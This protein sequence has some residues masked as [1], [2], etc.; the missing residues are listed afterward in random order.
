[1]TQYCAGYVAKGKTISTYTS[2]AWTPSLEDLQCLE[3]AAL[4]VGGMHDRRT[5]LQDIEVYTADGQ[6][7]MLSDL[8]QA[9]S[10]HSVDYIDGA[11]LLCGG[12]DNDGGRRSSRDK[13][14]KGEYQPST[15]GTL[16]HGYFWSREQFNSI[17]FF[18]SIHTEQYNF[19]LFISTPQKCNLH[20]QFCTHFKNKKCR[21]LTSSYFACFAQTMQSKQAMCHTCTFTSLIIIYGLTISMLAACNNC[22]LNIIHRYNCAYLALMGY[23]MI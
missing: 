10:L 22:N 6:R 23:F 12:K 18:I 21:A 20:T 7:R 17:Q 5:R 9:I 2:E 13:C 15:K 1:M 8:P 3:G 16:V 11:L 14:L 4:I 19:L